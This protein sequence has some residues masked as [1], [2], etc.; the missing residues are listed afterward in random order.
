VQAVIDVRD[1]EDKDS[2]MF[3][4]PGNYSLKFTDVKISGFSHRN[5]NVRCIFIDIRTIQSTT[6]MLALAYFRTAFITIYFRF[7]S[8][9]RDN[10]ELS[11]DF[12]LTVHH[13]LGKVI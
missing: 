5:V 3:R 4:D 2:G 7:H 12:C 10:Q 6:L 8:T 13:Q 11:L 1:P 9:T